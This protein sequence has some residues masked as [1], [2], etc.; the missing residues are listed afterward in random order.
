MTTSFESGDT[1]YE[2]HPTLSYLTRTQALIRALT[3][4]FLEMRLAGGSNIV[5]DESQDIPV[6][7]SF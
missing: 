6:L 1:G 7:V 2:N 4:A 5:L 3:D